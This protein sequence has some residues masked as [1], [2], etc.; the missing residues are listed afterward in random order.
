MAEP[1]LAVPLEEATGADVAALQREGRLVEALDLLAALN[2]RRPSPNWERRLVRLRHEAFAQARGEGRPSW[3]PDV[4]DPFP[5]VVGAIPE[6][7][8]DGLDAA[9]LGGGILHHGAVIVRGLL[10]P[11]A[12]EVLVEDIDRTFEAFDRRQAEGAPVGSPGDD[13]WLTLFSSGPDY[14]QLG[15]FRRHWVREAGGVWTVDSP[16]ALGHVLDAFQDVGLTAAIAEHLGERPAL[17]VDKC[18]LRRVPV[19]LSATEWHQD[20]AFLGSGIRTVNAWLALS[21]CGAGAP[22][23]GMELLAGRLHEVQPT[24]THGAVFDWSVGAGLIEELAADHPVVQPRF[25]PGDVVLFDELN[26]HRTAVDPV[27]EERYAVETW[28]FAPSAYPD[29]QVP[30]LA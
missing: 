3:P 21:E 25:H 23:Q 17:A 6:I 13:P 2:R 15:F 27:T 12:V 1:T 30:L 7:A 5:E 18:T 19:D 8:P 16:R 20:G 28:F 10:P 26:L 24:G 11:P 22:A 4:P 14:P 9:T 29:D